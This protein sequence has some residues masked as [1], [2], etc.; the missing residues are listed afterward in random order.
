MKIT[1]IVLFL[2]PFLLFVTTFAENEKSFSG[3]QARQDDGDSSINCLKAFDECRADQSCRT[4]LHGLNRK[5]KVVSERCSAEMVDLPRCGQIMDHLFQY[6]FP[7]NK[8]NCDQKRSDRCLAILEKIYDNPCFVSIRHLRKYNLFPKAVDAYDIASS[9]VATMTV[10]TENINFKKGDQDISS[11]YDE[12]MD[13]APKSAKK[14]N[15]KSNFDN[16]NQK[17][18]NQRNT[19]SHKTKNKESTAST[20]GPKGEI[21]TA[22]QVNNEEETEQ[23]S[24]GATKEITKH[25]SLSEVTQTTYRR[26]KQDETDY[27]LIT[28]ILGILLGICVFIT[29]I[30]FA[31]AR[32][33]GSIFYTKCKT[34]HSENHHDDATVS[35]SASKQPCITKTEETNSEHFYSKA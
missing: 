11:L 4:A 32:L 15:E 27:K 8:C 10:T 5:C 33:T 17:S 3:K 31:W 9:T 24:R 18:K 30:Y 13:D 12:V 6:G 16:I 21:K 1:S 19:V 29:V 28:I 7:E 34:V 25:F 35:T 26:R 22:K 23:K 2:H 20:I 14:Q